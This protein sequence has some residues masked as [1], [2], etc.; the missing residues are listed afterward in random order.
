MAGAQPYGSGRLFPKTAS[1]ALF[2][3]RLAAARP[4]LATRAKQA[5]HALPAVRW[6]TPT[7]IADPRKAQEVIWSASALSDDAGTLSEF[8]TTSSGVQ[9]PRLVYSVMSQKVDTQDLVLSAVNAG[10]RGLQTDGGA[11]E[12]DVGA[13]L[14]QLKSSGVARDSLFI[15]SSVNPDYN[16]ESKQTQSITQQVQESIQNSLS[17]MQL[18]YIDSLVLQFPYPE[19][20]QTMEAWRAMEDAVRAGLVRQLGI[21]HVPFSQLTKMYNDVVVK[22]AVVYQRGPF[23]GAVRDFR[24]MGAFCNHDRR[25]KQ[26]III[27]QAGVLYANPP[28]KKKNR[29]RTS[30]NLRD[31]FEN[32]TGSRPMR[33]MA[34]KYNVSSSMLFYRFLLGLGIVPLMSAGKRSPVQLKKFLDAYRVPLAAHDSATIS[35]LLEQTGQSQEKIIAS[36]Q[37]QVRR[38][39]ETE[40][41]EA[42]DWDEA[43]DSQH[44]RTMSESPNQRKRGSRMREVTAV[45]GFMKSFMKSYSPLYLYHAHSQQLGI[46]N[47]TEKKL[48]KRLS[49]KLT[50]Q[51]SQLKSVNE[52][53]SWMERLERELENGDVQD[54]EQYAGTGESFEDWQIRLFKNFTVEKLKVTMER[55]RNWKE[56]LESELST[57]ASPS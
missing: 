43:E 51:K 34:W 4:E 39:E 26:R 6:N 23:W 38:K 31:A 17:D 45:T 48:I 18:E 52:R 41:G 53:L 16:V 19:H 46:A 44:R 29:R 27:Q 20:E 28:S 25:G 8:V 7:F 36:Q 15:Q 30:L 5:L 1:M 10:F 35:D 40:V 55:N 37:L 33:R 9:M 13:A 21:A 2:S 3:E 12:L 42:D 47:M 50:V 56:E 32:F 24:E 22:P 14:S 57:A 54:I 11:K 49:K